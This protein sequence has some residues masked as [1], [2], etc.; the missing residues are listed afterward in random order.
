MEATSAVVVS[1]CPILASRATKVARV[2][3]RDRVVIVGAEC[4]LVLFVV[5]RAVTL[6]KLQEGPP[7]RSRYASEPGNQCSRAG[8]TGHVSSELRGS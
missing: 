1:R 5:V 2:R 3:S 7:S 6:Q 4:Q 8:R